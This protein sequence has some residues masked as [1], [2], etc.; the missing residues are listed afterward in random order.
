[1]PERILREVCAEALGLA[2]FDEGAFRERVERIDIPEHGILL[3]RFKDGTAAA[4]RW[5]SAAKKE[6]WTPQ[7]R[8]A[9]SEQL[10]K[11]VNARGRK[12]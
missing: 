2:E 3:F 9:H 4:K 12:E 10:R 1:V 7:R 11:R 5:V 6:S 8:A